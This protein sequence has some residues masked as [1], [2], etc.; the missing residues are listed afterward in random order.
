[1][2]MKGKLFDVEFQELDD[3]RGDAGQ[4]G[5][6]EEMVSLGQRAS[7]RGDGRAEVF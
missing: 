3:D 5:P 7:R 2:K 4:G 1:M 6:R